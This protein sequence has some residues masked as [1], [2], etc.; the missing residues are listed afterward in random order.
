MARWLNTPLDDVIKSAENIYGELN[1]SIVIGQRL[2]EEENAYGMTS[3]NDDGT[4]LVVLDSEQTYS[5]MMETLAH[6]L[7]H[8]VMGKEKTSHDENWKTT[9]NNIFNEYNRYGKEKYENE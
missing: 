6:E 5:T 1:C 7:A 4:V 2:M 9:F 8:V 3:F